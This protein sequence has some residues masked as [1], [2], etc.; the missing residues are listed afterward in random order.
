MKGRDPRRPFTRKE[1][2]SIQLAICG[3]HEFKEGYLHIQR[4]RNRGLGERNPE[5][6]RFFETAFI[7]ILDGC[8]LLTGPQLACCQFSGW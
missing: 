4:L 3:L 1:L 6:G 5:L 2:K 8:A 7:A